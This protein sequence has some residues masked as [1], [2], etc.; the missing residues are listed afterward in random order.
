[1]ISKGC[2]VSYF[3]PHVMFFIKL[4]DL[5]PHPS[6]AVLHFVGAN[7][8][9]SMFFFSA[10]FPDLNENTGLYNQ[11]NSMWVRFKPQ[12]CNRRA[13]SALPSEKPSCRV[14]CL[15]GW[16]YFFLFCF[17]FVSAVTATIR[18]PP[19]W[20]WKGFYIVITG[21]GSLTDEL[22]PHALLKWRNVMDDKSHILW[23]IL[24]TRGKKGKM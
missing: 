22:W 7:I 8:P 3:W 1:M 23:A 14:D 20:G 15:Q 10:V 17:R 24:F 13:D 18:E 5:S 12:L 21:C 9:S 6:S 2:A 19:W 4:Y 16:K 11:G